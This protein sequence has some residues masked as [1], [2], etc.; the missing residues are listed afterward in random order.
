MQLP[1]RTGGCFSAPSLSCIQE[2]LPY[3]VFPIVRQT[4]LVPPISVLPA[5]S[6]FAPGGVV[7]AP[8]PRTPS[9]H[10]HVPLRF[11]LVELFVCRPQRSRRPIVP[12]V[13]H[14]CSTKVHV[15]T[16]VGLTRTRTTRDGRQTRLHAESR[17]TQQARRSYS[18]FAIR[19]RWGNGCIAFVSVALDDVQGPG[20]QCRGRGG[21]RGGRGLAVAATSE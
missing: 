11:A 21:S 8:P 9:L 17:N 16:S 4:L 15:T 13:R 3:F 1:T 5:C 18:G 19:L 10:M 2:H 6:M 12:D 7:A 14:I 20:W